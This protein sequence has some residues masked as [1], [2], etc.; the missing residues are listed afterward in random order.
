MILAQ[1]I[2]N[3]STPLMSV[4]H[5]PKRPDLV[6]PLTGNPAYDKVGHAISAARIAFRSLNVAF[7]AGD[8]AATAD[9]M[10]A[11]ER[12]WAATSVQPGPQ[13]E[14]L[15]QAEAVADATPDPRRGPE[16]RQAAV[17]NATPKPKPRQAPP[18]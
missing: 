5:A 13:P 10:L 16:N 6:V 9:L 4:P 7:T 8:L 3:R 14:P 17:A 11:V 12:E 2:P 15:K 18:C 1:G